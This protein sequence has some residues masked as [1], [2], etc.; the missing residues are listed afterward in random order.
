[1]NWLDNTMNYDNVE[2]FVQENTVNR[3]K[4]ISPIQ[5]RIL[6]NEHP[7]HMYG[8]WA[9]QWTKYGRNWILS[10][11]RDFFDFY[12]HLL[13]TGVLPLSISKYL[14]IKTLD[15]ECISIHQ[16]YPVI[17]T[18]LWPMRRISPKPP[19]AKMNTA[20]QHIRRDSMSS[21]DKAETSKRVGEHISRHI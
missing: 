14:I 17:I 2:G 19:W 5:A 1:M 16:H 18:T 13:L 21:Q 8:T 12:W 10:C 15:Y 20:W 7:C 3:F 11:V 4:L 9:Y 6:T